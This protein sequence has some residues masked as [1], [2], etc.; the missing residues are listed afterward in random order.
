MD[1]WRAAGGARGD[2][3]SSPRR[4]RGGPIDAGCVRIAFD[5]QD[6]RGNAP[7]DGAAL[8]GHAARLRLVVDAE[9]DMR[10]RSRGVRAPL[11][12]AVPRGAE[13]HRRPR[14]N[15]APGA[16]A[17]AALGR[18]GLNFGGGAPK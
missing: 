18:Q 2:R 7:V 4:S 16:G 5:R 9:A 8:R 13:R 1:V 10:P 14:A 12:L 3:A 6:R 11:A 15:D 17:P